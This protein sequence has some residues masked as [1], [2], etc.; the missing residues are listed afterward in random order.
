MGGFVSGFQ[1]SAIGIR[2]SAIG[3]GLHMG[4][5]LPE[6]PSVIAFVDMQLCSPSLPKTELVDLHPATSILLLYLMIESFFLKHRS[7]C[8]YGGLG[9]KIMS[10]SAR[11][12]LKA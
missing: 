4:I 9:S 2:F 6:L 7:C 3:V 10:L 5:F 11:V 12:F 8:V 1:F